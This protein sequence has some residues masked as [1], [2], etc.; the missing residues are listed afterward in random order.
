MNHKE[1]LNQPYYTKPVN[2]TQSNLP[3][4]TEN[5][6]NNSFLSK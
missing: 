5:L 1:K 3:D 6:D 2:K 4:K